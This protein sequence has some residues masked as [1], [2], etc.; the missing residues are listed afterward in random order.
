MTTIEYEQ[1]TKE[2]SSENHKDGGKPLFKS[3]KD[4]ENMKHG[5]SAIEYMPDASRDLVRETF[6]NK[7]SRKP[8]S[9][10][11]SKR[12]RTVTHKFSNN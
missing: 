1:R 9:D 7:I 2:I 12:C 11:E 8:T 6:K 3:R 10:K 4:L 5:E